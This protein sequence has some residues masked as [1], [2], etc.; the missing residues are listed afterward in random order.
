[1]QA[2]CAQDWVT[3]RGSASVATL[4]QGENAWL[5]LSAYQDV[6]AWLDVREF[7][8]T[9]TNIPAV[10]YQTSPT[11]DESLFVPMS[12][13]TVVTGVTTTVLLKE[14]MPANTPPL[15][16]WFRWQIAVSGGVAWDLTFRLWIA[17][18]RIGRR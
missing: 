8:P 12:A 10:V 18:N 11:Q 7:T 1:M 4:T 5:D 13:V 3:V 9:S 6:V 15:A 17:V 2:I 16:R 14:A